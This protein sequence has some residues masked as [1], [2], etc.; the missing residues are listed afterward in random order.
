MAK[1]KEV[2]SP[3]DYR[4]YRNVRLVAVVFATEGSLLLLWALAVAAG[5][6][7][8]SG[9]A[10]LGAIPALGPIAAFGLAGAVGGIATLRGS[11]RWAPLLYV[12]AAVH[13][14]FFP[15][16]TIL[17]YVILTGLSRYLGSVERIRSAARQD[18]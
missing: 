14:I 6:I 5:I 15:I 16:G 8:T 17:G 4:N 13:I 7:G 18:A 2:L 10:A 1:P 9:I 12:M 11:R 3:A